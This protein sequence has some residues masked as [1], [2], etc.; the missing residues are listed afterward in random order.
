MLCEYYFIGKNFLSIFFFI[1]YTKVYY[2]M[3]R[4]HIH[5]ILT[6]KKEEIMFYNKETIKIQATKKKKKTKNL[7]EIPHISQ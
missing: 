6:K 2:I 1:E 3:F 7:I 5:L 4:L